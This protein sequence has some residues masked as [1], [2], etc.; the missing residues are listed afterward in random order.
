MVSH[1]PGASIGSIARKIA[2]RKQYKRE[3]SAHQAV[4]FALLT[5]AAPFERKA[6]AF[7]GIVTPL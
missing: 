1:G 5:E 2:S 3:P 4:G 6:S 7:V